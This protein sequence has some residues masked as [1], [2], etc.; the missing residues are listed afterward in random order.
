MDPLDIARL[1]T[2]PAFRDALHDHL[3]DFLQCNLRVDLSYSMKDLHGT[4]EKALLIMPE[5]ELGG[6][7]GSYFITGGGI[8]IPLKDI[9]EALYHTDS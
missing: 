8:E 5:I 2:D 4:N 3:R 9:T 6:P 7:C 1:V